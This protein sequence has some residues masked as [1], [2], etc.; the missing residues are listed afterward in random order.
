VANISEQA[1]WGKELRRLGIAG[2]LAQRRNA[3][4]PALARRL[5]RVLA[6]PA[7]AARAVDLAG[8]MKDEHGVDAAVALVMHTFAQRHVTAA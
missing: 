6:S 5:R 1:H 7:M 8:A 4:A 2:R 3:T